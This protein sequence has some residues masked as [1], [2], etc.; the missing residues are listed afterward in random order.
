MFGR[1]RLYREIRFRSRIVIEKKIICK[2]QFPHA[3]IAQI[4]P[5][6][7]SDKNSTIRYIKSNHMHRPHA[8]NNCVLSFHSKPWWSHSAII[9][10]MII[11]GNDVRQL[12]P[13]ILLRMTSTAARASPWTDV[14]NAS[15]SCRFCLL[16]PL[17]RK[18]CAQYA[19]T[20][21]TVLWAKHCFWGACD[22]CDIPCESSH[23]LWAQRLTHPFRTD[24]ATDI[25][26]YRTSFVG[27]EK[28]NGVDR[29]RILEN[30]QQKKKGEGDKNEVVLFITLSGQMCDTN[31]RNIVIRCVEVREVVKCRRKRLTIFFP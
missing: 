6:R 3:N 31:G 1:I 28:K 21:Y 17:A 22:T 30:W 29:I 11:D 24:I 15:E 10:T 16:S 5:S 14:I 13:V 27:K 23:F 2:H 25:L 19:L 26:K 8:H 12:L 20:N 7:H 9:L 18:M 4:H